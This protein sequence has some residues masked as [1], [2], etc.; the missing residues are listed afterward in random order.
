M[1]KMNSSLTKQIPY[2]IDN[3][4]G[5]VFR[6]FWN[7]SDRP[8]S[9]GIGHKIDDAFDIFENDMES[10]TQGTQDITERSK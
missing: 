3:Y 5:L 8:R 9:W 2:H 1:Q 4:S 10:I 7:L 6:A